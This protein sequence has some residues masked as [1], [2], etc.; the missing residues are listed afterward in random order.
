MAYAQKK[1]RRNVLFACAKSNGEV[2]PA[3]NDKKKHKIEKRLHN[4]EFFVVL[5]PSFAQC[6][7]FLYCRAIACICSCI[8]VYV[9]SIYIPGTAFQYGF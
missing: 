5:H 1:Y 3:T 7:S 2:V 6:C 8:L 4:T 9:A